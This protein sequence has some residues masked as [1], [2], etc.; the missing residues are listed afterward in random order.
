MIN[1]KHGDL[2]DVTEGVIVHG[3][4]A[5]GVMGSG[6]ALAIKM[7]YPKAYQA[8]KEFETKH[9]LRLSSLSIVKVS[10]KLYIAN[11]ISQET[12]GRDTNIK[13]V[14]YGAVHLG[15]E[16]LQEHFPSNMP[17]HFPKIGAG[18][19][20]GDWTKISGLIEFA[21]PHRELICWEL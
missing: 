1:Y 6:V 4:N 17:F 19:G 14:S 20:N 13:Y 5:K 8:Y 18:L 2:L 16:N 9:V 3:C 12:Y 7:K 21:C 10:P 15:F 11:L